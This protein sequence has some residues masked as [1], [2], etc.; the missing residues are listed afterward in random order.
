MIPSIV[1]TSH[2]EV[3]LYRSPS[4]GLPQLFCVH[5]GMGLSSDSL[6]EGILPLSAHF[7]LIFIDQRGCGKSNVSKNGSYLLSDFAD[8]I[9]EVVNQTRATAHIGLFGH[10]MGG[11]IAIETLS[12]YPDLFHFSILANT[13]MDDSWRS[14]ANSA[15]NRIMSDEIRNAVARY[16]ESPQDNMRL[17]DLAVAYGPLYFNELPPDRAR[18]EMMKFSYSTGA[19]AF[20][21][22]KVFPGMNLTVKAFEIKVPTLIISGAADMIVPTRCQKM[23]SDTIP[24]STLAVVE[25]SAHFPFVTNQENFYQQVSQW[26]EE[27]RRKSI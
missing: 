12:K 6:F 16:D 11:M 9:A 13:A 1:K 22:K 27:T 19:I 25:G 21:N 5:G 3:A 26:W 23:L 24:N 10:S 4:R 18:A 2:G 7:D 20:M 17:R 14:D 8:D 15:V